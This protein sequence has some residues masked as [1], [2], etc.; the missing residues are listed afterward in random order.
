MITCD[1][2]HGYPLTHF[3]EMIGDTK[4]RT[5]CPTCAALR[6]TRY[7]ARA[8]RRVEHDRRRSP[9]RKQEAAQ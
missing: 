6:A 2:C 8:K 9:R 7:I 1:E 4:R 5:L 3:V